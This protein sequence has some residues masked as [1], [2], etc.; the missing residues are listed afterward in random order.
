MPDQPEELSEVV[1]PKL[2]TPSKQEVRGA[3][4]ITDDDIE[5]ALTNIWQET[6]GIG[7]VSFNDNFFDLGGSSLMA[8]RVFA[9][10]E[11][12]FGKRLPLATLIQAPTVE[13]LADIM[14]CGELP[15]SRTS[16]V[17]IQPGDSKPPFFLIHAAGGNVLVYRDLVRHLNLEQPVYGLQAQGLDGEQP[18]H[19]RIEDMAAHYVQEIQTVQ[20]EGPYF[21]SGY[22]MGGTV[23]LE[24][25][26]QLYAQGKEVALLVLMETYNFS[27][28]PRALLNR[29]HYRVQQI[30]FHLRNLL[31]SDRKRIFLKEKAKV[32]WSRKDVLFGAISSR[33]GLNSS[34][35]NGHYSAL[36]DVWTACDRAAANYVPKVYPGRITQFRPF[37]PYA[38]FA[39]PALGWDNLADGG[40]ET[41]DLPIYPRGMLVEPFVALLSGKL[42]DCIQ[43][44]LEPETSNESDKVIISQY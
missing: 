2:T 36:A 30:E 9:E 7:K 28:E 22:C 40:L 20:P 4:D 25:A 19:T 39:G 8:V 42:R 43:R 16:L 31:L 44:A 11:K 23:A 29:V 6:L 33:L 21:L 41:Y 26:Q 18:F 32:A 3:L 15:S 34:L 14:R 35:V 12:I 38:S 27:S 13:Q 1:H 37:K 10:I 17:E 5:Q 24:M